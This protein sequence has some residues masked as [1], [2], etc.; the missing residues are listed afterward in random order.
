MKN[1]PKQG[2]QTS[3]T[4]FKGLKQ[5]KNFSDNRIKLEVNNKKVSRKFLDIGKLKHHTS[6]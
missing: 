1:S 3:L 6:K 4:N 5:L 2:H